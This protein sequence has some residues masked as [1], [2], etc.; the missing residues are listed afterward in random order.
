ML[1]W[2]KFKKKT[3]PQAKSPQ[4]EI[5]SREQ[6]VAT[7]LKNMQETRD[8]IG[9]EKLQ[10]LA[11]LILQK[12]QTVDDTSPAAQAK[13]IIAQMDK[14]KLHDFMKLMVQDDQTKH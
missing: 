4:K 1:N 6:L 12:K 11:Q 14:A 8:I 5:Q 2:L 3:V 13:K 10:K 9:E 7:A